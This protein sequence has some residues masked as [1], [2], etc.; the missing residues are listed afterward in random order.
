MIERSLEM[1]SRNDW[2]I[3]GWEEHTCLLSQEYP[4]DRIKYMIEDSKNGY[5]A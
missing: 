5:I 3:K 4:K 1:I 2:G